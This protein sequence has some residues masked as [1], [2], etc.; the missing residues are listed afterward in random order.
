MVVDTRVLFLSSMA[1]QMFDEIGGPGASSSPDWEDTL[2][3]WRCVVAREDG[4]TLPVVTLRN[5]HHDVL[6]SG[7]SCYDPAIDGCEETKRKEG[8]KPFSRNQPS[9]LIQICR[10]G[11]L[12]TYSIHI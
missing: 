5:A 3:I 2:R 12:K 4:L 6:N 8:G 7:A 11:S 9:F 1:I 10:F